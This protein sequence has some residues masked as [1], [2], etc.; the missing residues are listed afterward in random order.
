MGPKS[1]FFPSDALSAQLIRFCMSKVRAAVPGEVIALLSAPLGRHGHPRSV[2]PIETHFAWV[3]LAGGNA[4]KLKKPMR[5]TSMDYRTLAARERGC[6]NEVLLNRRLA[7]GVYLRALPI[8]QRRAGGLALGRGSAVRDWVI[9]MR[10]LPAGGMLDRAIVERRVKR[11]DLHRIARR[12]ARFF[13]R[14]E[15]RPMS[16][17]LYLARLRRQILANAR[18]LAARDLALSRRRIE[19]VIRSQLDFLARGASMLARR[20][21]RLL[22]GHGD[23]RP[24]HVYVG[25]RNSDACVIDCLEFDRDLRRLDPAEEVAFLALECERLDARELAQ[26]LIEQYRRS[27]SD[28]VTDAVFQFYLSRRAATRARIAAWHLRD[29]QFAG[30]RREWKARAHS[31][32]GDALDHIR[33]AQRALSAPATEPR[34]LAAPNTARVRARRHGLPATSSDG[35]SGVFDKLRH[36]REKLLG[37]QRLVRD[38][39][40]GVGLQVLHRE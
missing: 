23:L 21:S 11:S 6:R 40:V 4:Y 34:G 5:Q 1:V 31:Y 17:P 18:A 20:G 27:A 28:P 13:R 7:P 3:F 9:E 36:Q 37:A 35:R 38:P 24:E 39:Q 26:E 14:A 22:D 15:P 10:R 25:T 16:G 33:A 30:E 19:R 12:L 32:L 29:P 2:Q 8:V